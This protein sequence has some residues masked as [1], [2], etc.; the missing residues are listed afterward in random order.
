MKP[1]LASTKYMS[2]IR[3]ETGVHC[4]MPENRMISSR[5]HQKIGIEKP[6]SETPITVWSRT[7]PRL[8]AARMP[9]GMPITSASSMATDRQLDR[10]REQGEE[11]AQ[12]RLAGDDRAA[13]IAVQQVAEEAQILQHQRPVEAE[14]GHHLGM[15]L[16]ADAAL[17][18]H[19]QDRIAR[20][21]ADQDEGDEGDAEEGR[22]QDR[23]ARAEKAEHVSGPA[24]AGCLLDAAPWSSSRRLSSPVRPALVLIP[25]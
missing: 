5:P 1:V 20:E 2:E 22:D 11:L 12:H 18:D 16:R 15:A 24:D 4:R 14:L 6:V 7:E 13:E 19:Q 9:A 17:A 21:Q 3:P 8:T 25:G 23:E 10:G